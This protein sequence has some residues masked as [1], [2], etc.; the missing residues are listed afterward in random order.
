MKLKIDLYLTYI[1]FR[2]YNKLPYNKFYKIRKFLWDKFWMKFIGY[3]F[4]T[5][6]DWF[7]SRNCWEI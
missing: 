1:V 2:I 6:E 3:G 4:Y 5:I 7:N